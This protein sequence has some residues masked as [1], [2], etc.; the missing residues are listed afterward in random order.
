MEAW[1]CLSAGGPFQSAAW[2][3]F[4]KQVMLDC[5]PIYI[6]LSLDNQPVERGTFWL[7]RNEPLPVSPFIQRMLT[8]CLQRWS[9]L[10]CRSPLANS[11]SLILPDVPWHENTLRVIAETA[12]RELRRLRGPF[13]LFDY[14]QPN[15]AKWNGWPAHSRPM[16]VSGPGTQLALRPSGFD[17]Y[18]KSN[19]KFRIHQHFRRSSQEATDLG[20]QIRRQASFDGSASVLELIHNVER[21]HES[22]PNPRAAEMFAHMGMVES[23]WLTA[24]IGDRLA[25]CIL[26]Q[27]DGDAQIASLPCLT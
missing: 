6:I 4:S 11:F 5:S 7:V 13:L 24:S 16:V 27:A 22:S 23:T 25:G 9:L 2:Y 26:L 20:F 17:G 3:R 14:L 12:F 10:I 15:Q 21:R 18:L 19:K 1:D 8:P